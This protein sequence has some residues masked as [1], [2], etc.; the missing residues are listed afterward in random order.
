MWVSDLYMDEVMIFSSTIRDSS[1]MQVRDV[2][3]RINASQIIAVILA[4]LS[5]MCFLS[6]FLFVARSFALFGVT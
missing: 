3:R 2:V 6:W 5:L 1:D 4:F